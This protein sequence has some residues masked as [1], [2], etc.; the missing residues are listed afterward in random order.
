MKRPLRVGC[1]AQHCATSPAM[2]KVELS[3]NV[4]CVRIRHCCIRSAEH[5]ANLPGCV[6]SGAQLS[7]YPLH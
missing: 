7:K 4:E 3:T 6:H 1:L 2:C 5:C